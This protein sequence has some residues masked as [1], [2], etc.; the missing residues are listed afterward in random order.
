MLRLLQ[1]EVKV[2]AGLYAKYYFHMRNLMTLMGM[3]CEDLSFEKTLDVE[4]AK[5]L[6]LKEET[7]TNRRSVSPI[8]PPV[9]IKSSMDL[10]SLSSLSLLE[11]RERDTSNDSNPRAHVPT[12]V[13]L[14]HILHS[15]HRDADGM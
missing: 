7:L 12:G 9:R 15:D 3:S 11:G 1:F 6:K 2:G 13:A 14:E 5:R 10:F 4:T 8:K